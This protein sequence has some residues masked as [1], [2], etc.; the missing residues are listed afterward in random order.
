[1]ATFSYIASNA[2]GESVRGNVSANDK[3]ELSRKLKDKGLFLVSCRM[4]EVNGNGS[5]RATALPAPPS[6]STLRLQSGSA[7]AVSGVTT[8]GAASI[9]S[10]HAWFSSV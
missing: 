6:R 4:E 10:A 3:N 5:V 8:S 7:P 2:Q 1:M 9:P